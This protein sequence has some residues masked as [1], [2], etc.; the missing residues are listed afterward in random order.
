L[1]SHP[2]AKSC[3]ATFPVKVSGGDIASAWSADCPVA[4]KLDCRL[5][6]RLRVLAGERNIGFNELVDE[7][8]RKGLGET[9]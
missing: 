3:I 7:L 5:A 1:I 6:S 2:R 4:V 9:G 8:L